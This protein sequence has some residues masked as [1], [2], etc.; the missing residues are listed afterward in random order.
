[1]HKGQFD[2][3]VGILYVKD[4]I[5]NNLSFDKKVGD[6]ARKDVFFVDYDKPLDELLNAFRSK[7]HHLFVVLGEYGSVSG[8]V[9]IEDVLEEIIGAEIM[10]EYDKYEDLQEVAKNKMKK[11][12]INKV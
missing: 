6:I 12:K 1:M 9:T 4:L 7:R 3:I 2:D 5:I 10:D 8:I 11:R